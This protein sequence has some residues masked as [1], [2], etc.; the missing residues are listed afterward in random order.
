MVLAG[1]GVFRKA[2]RHKDQGHFKDTTWTSADDDGDPSSRYALRR[3]ARERWTMGMF[4]T[5]YPL[6]SPV[7]VSRF[8]CFAS[9][10][11]QYDMSRP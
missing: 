8:W 3:G 5:R 9:R 4:T 7:I 10:E 11:W 2:L 6:S 1:A